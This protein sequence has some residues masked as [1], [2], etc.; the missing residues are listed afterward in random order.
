M[1]KIIVI[2]TFVALIPFS[3]ALALT[4]PRPYTLTSVTGIQLASGACPSGTTTIEILDTPD[5]LQC[6]EEGSSI[7]FDRAFCIWYALDGSD[8]TGYYNFEP[9]CTNAS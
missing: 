1:K 8:S 2:F 7:F 3:N 6:T 5:I 4:C 9:P